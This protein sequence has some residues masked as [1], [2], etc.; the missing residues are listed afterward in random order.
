[1]TSYNTSC[2]S[3]ELGPL[4]LFIFLPSCLCCNH[5]SI[6][7]VIMLLVDLQ[8]LKMLGTLDS[9]EKGEGVECGSHSLHNFG[10][11]NTTLD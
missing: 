11:I 2:A 4:I 7:I 6:I 9:M 1:M 5:T 3:I 8:N 10:G